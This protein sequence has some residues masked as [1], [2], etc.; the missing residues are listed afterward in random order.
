M[1]RI[2]TSHYCYKRL[3]RKWTKVATVVTATSKRGCTEMT[4]VPKPAARPALADR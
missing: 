2:V 4:G 3:S 1:T